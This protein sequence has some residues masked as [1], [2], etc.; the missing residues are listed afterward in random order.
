[1]EENNLGKFDFINPEGNPEVEEGEG[2]GM[3]NPEE[4]V[5]GLKSSFEEKL[6][7]IKL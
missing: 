4:R 3:L 1:V 5:N 6:S 7:P 2:D